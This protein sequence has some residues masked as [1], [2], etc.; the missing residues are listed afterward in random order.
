V[1]PA[2]FFTCQASQ[3]SREFKGS[4]GN[5][6]IEEAQHVRKM[7]GIHATENASWIDF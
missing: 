3:F 7:L 2:F 1:I 4:F 5:A 6:P